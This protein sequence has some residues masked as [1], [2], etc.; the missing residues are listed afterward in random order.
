M[1]I[2][3]GRAAPRHPAR[4]LQA[5]GL[6]ANVVDLETFGYTVVPPE[7]SGAAPDLADRLLETICTLAAQRSNGIV[8]DRRTGSTHGE[9]VSPV[10]QMLYYLLGTTR[11]S[12][13]RS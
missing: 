4:E 7:Q 13:S 5:L 6:A 2:K 10:G 9:R 3:D 8:P 1:T 11:C 12:S